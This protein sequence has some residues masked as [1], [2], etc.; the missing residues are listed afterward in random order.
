MRVTRHA[1]LASE[2]DFGQIAKRGNAVHVER[3]VAFSTVVE[4]ILALYNLLT[5]LTDVVITTIN[6]TSSDQMQMMLIKLTKMNPF[7]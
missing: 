1:T 4:P 7:W 2:F 5:H 3:V 6:S